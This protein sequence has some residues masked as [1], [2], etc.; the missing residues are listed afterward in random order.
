MKINHLATLN[1]V[2]RFLLSNQ[3]EKFTI[4]TMAPSVA[5]AAKLSSGGPIKG[6]AKTITSVKEVSSGVVKMV[7]VTF[8]GRTLL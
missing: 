7:F 3:Q 5:T 1:F 6:P 4:L 8:C 2:R